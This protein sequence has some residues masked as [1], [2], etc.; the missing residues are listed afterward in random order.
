MGHWVSMGYDL[1]LSRVRYALFGKS[2]NIALRAIDEFKVTETAP[3]PFVAFLFSVVDL[4][5]RG[6]KLDLA[7]DGDFPVHD[8]VLGTVHIN[9][10]SGC[11]GCHSLLMCYRERAIQR[12]SKREV[13][14]ERA[15][16]HEIKI[17]REKK[18]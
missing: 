17:E 5:V 14:W 12:R 6:Y 16:R 2:V 8:W 13:E 9:F 10:H 11:G 1:D 18:N 3:V 7:V 4:A 15:D